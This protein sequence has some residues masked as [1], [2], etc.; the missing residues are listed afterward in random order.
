MKRSKWIARTW[1]V[2]F[3]AM[4]LVAAKIWV[5]NDFIHLKQAQATLI[6]K[7]RE[8]VPI[9]E[10][11]RRVEEK[12]HKLR[13]V[14]HIR[15]LIEHKNELNQ[16]LNEIIEPDTSLHQYINYR[17]KLGRQYQ[18]N[19]GLICPIS[20]KVESSFNYLADYLTNLESGGLPLWVRKIQFS[21]AKYEYDH[22]M[23]YLSGSILLFN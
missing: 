21:P 2:P 10:K 20:L 16:L 5:F 8:L 17:L 4:W 9:M 23:L 1:W 12:I 14:Q 22:V 11:S 15:E 7:E 3:M 6:E 19:A 18:T 13:K